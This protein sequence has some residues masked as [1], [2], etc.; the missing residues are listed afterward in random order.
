MDWKKHVETM[1]PHIVRIVTPD[2]RGTGFILH[3][4]KAKRELVIAT[5][6]HVIRDA[7][8]W[9]QAIDIEHAAFNGRLATVRSNRGILFHPRFD[10]AC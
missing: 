10:S 3:I 7:N 9:V 1:V 4:N 5:A 2:T 6:A 8:S